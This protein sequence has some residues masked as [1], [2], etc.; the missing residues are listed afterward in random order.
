LFP[1]RA[2]VVVHDERGRV[3]CVCP[4]TDEERALAF[5]GFEAGRGACSTIK[6]RYPAAAFGFENHDIRGLAKVKTRIGRALTVMMALTLGQWGP[7]TP[8]GCA[9][10]SARCRCATPTDP[11]SVF[12]HRRSTGPAAGK[13]RPPL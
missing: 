8:S 2:D 6:Y 11:S 7:A 5:Q 10:R 3:S 4:E 1:E 9:P 13:P 12:R